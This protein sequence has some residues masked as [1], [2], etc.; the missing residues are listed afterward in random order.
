MERNLQV[1][2]KDLFVWTERVF[3]QKCHTLTETVLIN[4]DQ[5][6]LCYERQT[7]KFPLKTKAVVVFRKGLFTW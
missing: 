5:C 2:G 1:A 7:P 6:W 4:V 3:I